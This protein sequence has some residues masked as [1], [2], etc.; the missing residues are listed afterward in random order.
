MARLVRELFGVPKPKGKDDLAPEADDPPWPDVKVVVIVNKR[1]GSR[2]VRPLVTPAPISSSSDSCAPL[3]A[4]PRL[5]LPLTRPSP[6]PSYQ[7]KQLARKLVEVR[8]RTPARVARFSS[9]RFS[10]RRPPP[11]RRPNA[12]ATPRRRVPS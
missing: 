11:V 1:S 3:P 5:P 10:L 8:S 9:A 7:G 12:R 6:A 4:T 2:L